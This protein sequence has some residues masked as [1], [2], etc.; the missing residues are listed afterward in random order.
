MVEWYNS[1]CVVTLSH[2]CEEMYMLNMPVRGMLLRHSKNSKAD[3]MEVVNSMLNLHVSPHG[4]LHCVV[5]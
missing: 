2:I 1:R 3:G 5:S 4:S